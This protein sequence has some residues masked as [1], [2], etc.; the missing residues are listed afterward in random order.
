MGNLLLILTNY[1]PAKIG[2]DADMIA[3]VMGI[4]NAI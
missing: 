4:F 1:S 2:F 3:W